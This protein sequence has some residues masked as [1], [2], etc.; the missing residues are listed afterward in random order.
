MDFW[1]EHVEADS[2]W[3]TVDDFLDT[4]EVQWWQDAD[5]TRPEGPEAPEKSFLGQKKIRD[6]LTPAHPSPPP[7]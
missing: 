4:S 2:E 3:D 1:D 5:K 7:S 6:F